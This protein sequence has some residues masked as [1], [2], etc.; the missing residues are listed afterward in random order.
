M[1]SLLKDLRGNRPVLINPKQAEAYL[2]RTANV[3]LPLGAKISD[4]GDML[5]ALFGEQPVL[6]KFPPYAIVPIKGVIGRGLTELE[7]LCGACDIKNV[8]EM[9]E[10]CERDPAIKTIILD[11]DS[12]GGTSV[13]VPELANRIKNS[14]K[15]VI[16]FTAGECCS[17]AYWLGSQAR[18]F[19][20]TPS[21]SIG[22]VGVYICFTDASKHYA[23]NGFRQ[24]VIKAGRLKGAGIDGTSLSDDQEKMLQDE[25]LDI[26][27]DFKGAVTSVREFVSEDAM[28][29]QPFSGKRG[30]E[31]G[32]CTSLVNGFDELMEALDARVAE[33]MEADEEND[34]RHE[35]AELVAGEEHDE[36][37]K[38]LKRFASAR[39]LNGLKEAKTL[40]KGVLPSPKAEKAA[41][42]DEDTEKAE[43]MPK[44]G[45]LPVEA[46]KPV[47]PSDPE[48]P[49]YDPDEDPEL[50]CVVSDFDGTIRVDDSDMLDEAVAKHLA[51]MTESGKQVHIVTGRHES[52]RAETEKYLEKNKVDFKA[53]HM[54]QDEKQETPRYKVDAVKKIEAEHG[55]VK[56]IVEND[57]ACIDAY[58]AE[59]WH[60]IHP[61]TLGK[62]EGEA[63][64]G[65]RGV[66]TDKKTDRSETERH[67]GGP[68]A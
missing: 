63:D 7:A 37:E 27:G 38:A 6:E 41:K 30:A 19:Y 17:A 12:P 56:H 40:A 13:G 67:R 58:E 15:E 68:I 54:K 61:D 1:K 22:S 66:D 49:D 31:V 18:S 20:A 55:K 5:A 62:V 11:I 60:C 32:L 46:G 26:W 3:E 2:A 23:D 25:V 51:R 47:D 34:A 45:R 64:A 29:G 4:V 9:L 33:Q 50:K 42:D 21:S 10:E 53:L 65:E 35:A 8:E 43:P 14:T 59:G 24:V 44:A 48:D 39:A 52:R 36:E 28:E 16:T 57:L